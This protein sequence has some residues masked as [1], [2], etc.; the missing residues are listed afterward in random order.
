M[1][2]IPERAVLPHVELIGK[3]FTRSYAVKTDAGYAIHAGRQNHSVPV[4][5]GVVCEMI[6]DTQGYAIALPP[7]QGRPRYGAVNYRRG[8]FPASEIDL[9]VTDVEIETLSTKRGDCRTGR[10]RRE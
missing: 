7:A 9:P 4:N 10:C 8:P 6:T 2:V 5:G 1:A 3:G